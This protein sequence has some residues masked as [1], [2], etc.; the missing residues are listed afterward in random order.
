MEDDKIEKEIY[1]N[2]KKIFSQKFKIN[3]DS[4]QK[5]IKCFL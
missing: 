3:N 4:K 5:K 2:R 1:N